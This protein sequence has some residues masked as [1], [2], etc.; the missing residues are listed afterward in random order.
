MLLKFG[1]MPLR[2][3]MALKIALPQSG[4]D[5]ILRLILAS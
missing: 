1:I 5:L 4:I 2:D 3:S